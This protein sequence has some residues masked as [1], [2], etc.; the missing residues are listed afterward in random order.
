MLEAF[1]K[2]RPELEAYYDLREA[3]GT[4]IN[5][6]AAK[7]VAVREK[8]RRKDA[9]ERQRAAGVVLPTNKRTAANAA[10]LVEERTGETG[11]MD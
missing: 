8:L 5:F 3:K 10:A 4:T 7:S 1:E 9:V 11:F 6:A 2:I